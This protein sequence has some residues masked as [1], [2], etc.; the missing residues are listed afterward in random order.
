MSII[1]IVYLFI[2]VIQVENVFCDKCEVERNISDVHYYAK[3][4]ET[5]ERRNGGGDE[6]QNGLLQNVAHPAEEHGHAVPGENGLDEGAAALQAAGAHGNVPEAVALLPHQAQ[7]S[8]AVHSTS[9]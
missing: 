1:V 9:E 7:I 8:A 3:K 5:R 6:G 2:D 4:T